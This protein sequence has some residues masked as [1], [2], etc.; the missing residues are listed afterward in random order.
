MKTEIIDSNTLDYFKRPYTNPPK[1]CEVLVKEFSINNKKDGNLIEFLDGAS[2]NKYKVFLNN[3][4]V[5]ELQESLKKSLSYCEIV[6]QNFIKKNR[7]ERNHRLYL[8]NNQLIVN[9]PLKHNIN[10]ELFLFKKCY[11]VKAHSNSCGGC[12]RYNAHIMLTFYIKDQNDV[13]DNIS[14]EGYSA[15]I[16]LDVF[17]TE[18]DSNNLFKELNK[19]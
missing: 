16:F 1:L 18:E 3:S 2:N 7:S 8:Q 13:P 17:L 4:Q 19:G 9:L 14:K 11:N 12:D 5:K 6:D 15:P 10:S